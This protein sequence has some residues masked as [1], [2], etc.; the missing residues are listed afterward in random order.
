[1]MARGHVLIDL[2]LIVLIQ[3]PRHIDGEIPEIDRVL[4][5]VP[6]KHWIQT[7]ENWRKL[8]RHM[9]PC[10]LALA[11]VNAGKNS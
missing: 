11:F 3:E 10:A 6:K 2:S 4:P 8:F 9:M 1:M 5:F 7:G